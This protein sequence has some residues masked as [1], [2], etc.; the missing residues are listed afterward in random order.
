MPPASLPA[1]ESHRLA[2]LHASGIL[3]SQPEASFDTLAQCAAQLT[4]CPIAVISL[5]D[6]ERE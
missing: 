2:T 5:V 6:S 1:D 3:D 4:G